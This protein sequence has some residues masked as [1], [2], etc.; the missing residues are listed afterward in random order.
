MEHDMLKLQ[1]AAEL[2]LD[3]VCTVLLISRGD[4]CYVLARYLRAELQKQEKVGPEK[5]KRKESPS[6]ETLLSYFR[7]FPKKY[8]KNSYDFFRNALVNSAQALCDGKELCTVNK[9][10]VR[11]SW[12]KYGE[13]ILQL[14]DKIH[15]QAVEA[16]IET[17]SSRN[18]QTIRQLLSMCE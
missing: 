15:K 8:L 6:E 7:E 3:D 5:K 1:S 10:A 18:R 16:Q 11:D 14:F 12:N 4:F 13:E 2:L 17:R 9:E